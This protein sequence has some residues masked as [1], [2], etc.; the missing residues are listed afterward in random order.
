MRSCIV[1]FLM[2]FAATAAAVTLTLPT[3]GSCI[4]LT[5]NMLVEWTATAQE[6]QE[7]PEVSFRLANYN[8]AWP[9]VNDPIPL[10]VDG[11][12]LTRRGYVLI[13]RMSYDDAMRYYS[14][15]NGRGFTIRI[16]R[17]SLALEDE[18]HLDENHITIARPGVGC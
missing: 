14:V 6:V 7:I 5:K 9:N 4:D 18:S 17:G 11:S 12:V 1:S 2:G 10:S 15:T 3:D 16:T 8:G 13:P